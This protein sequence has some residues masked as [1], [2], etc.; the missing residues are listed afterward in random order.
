MVF[1]HFPTYRPSIFLPTY[2]PIY[3]PTY[4]PSFLPSY[5]PT[6]LPTFLLTYSSIYLPT[7]VSALKLHN[8]KHQSQDHHKHNRSSVEEFG[9][10]N[11]LGDLG[12]VV[13]SQS[14]KYIRWRS[15]KTPLLGRTL[16]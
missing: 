6:Y 11:S 5:L 8:Y 16:C 9:V 2:L 10:F 1:Y 12:R 3:L 13:P 15:F 7:V 4:L 14:L